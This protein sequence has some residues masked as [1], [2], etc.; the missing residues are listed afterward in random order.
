VSSR[1]TDTFNL[2]HAGAPQLILQNVA[3]HRVAER[4]AISD[5]REVGAPQSCV[6]LLD[7]IIDVVRT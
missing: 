5:P 6:R 7:Q 4:T 2:H 1:V 3:N